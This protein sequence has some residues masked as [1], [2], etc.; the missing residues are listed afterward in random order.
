MSLASLTSVASLLK[1]DLNDTIIDNGRLHHWM[2]LSDYF[3]I[4]HYVDVF[5]INVKIIHSYYSI[6]FVIII[7]KV[8]HI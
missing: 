4:M 2:L 5:H 7:F 3:D 8:R 6:Y 1:N